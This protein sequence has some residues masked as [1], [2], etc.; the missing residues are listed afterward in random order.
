MRKKKK[1]E[2]THILYSKENKQANKQRKRKKTEVDM[3][4]K[5][6]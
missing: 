3:Y 4:T 5:K 1:R 2:I 6:F